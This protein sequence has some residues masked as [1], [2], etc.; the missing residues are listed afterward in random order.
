MAMKSKSRKYRSAEETSPRRVEERSARAPTSCYEQ[1]GR[2]DGFA[3]H[4]SLEAESE[5]RGTKKQAKVKAER[6]SRC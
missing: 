4:H 5:V 2:V 1:R 6:G 3:L